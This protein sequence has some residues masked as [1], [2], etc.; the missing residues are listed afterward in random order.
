MKKN[1]LVISTIASAVLF[2]AMTATAEMK[3]PQDMRFTGK[4]NIEG[5]LKIDNVEVTATAAELNALDASGGATATTAGNTNVTLTVKSITSASLTT[6]TTGVSGNFTIGTNLTVTDMIYTGN[7]LDAIGA[8]DMDYGSADVTDHTFT[9]D[10]TGDAEIVLPNDS[11][12]DAEI[13]FDE[14]TG[15][16]LTLTDCGRIVSAYSDGATDPTI[17]LGANTNGF[18]DVSA[19]QVGIVIRGVRVGYI[20]ADGLH[21]TAIEGYLAGKGVEVQYSAWD[22]TTTTIVL[23][24]N[25]LNQ[26]QWINTNAAVA[27]TLPANGMPSGSWIDIGIHSSAS[28]VCAPTISAATAD[29][30]ITPNSLDS[31]SVTWN[32][33]HRIGAYARFMSDGV[34]WHVQNLGGTTMTY[35]DSD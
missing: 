7:G 17:T 13:A 1:I 4:V 32:S 11:I 19:S 24:S 35:T 23:T 16:D 6:T 14:V 5:P 18:E 10:G 29:T 25:D 3:Q 20:Q 31:D 27:I 2:S 34:L 33:G 28:D 30:L 15:A 22:Y 12:G 9:T 8:V 21:V 26:I